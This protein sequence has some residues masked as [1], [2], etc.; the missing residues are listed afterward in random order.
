M[1]SSASSERGHPMHKMMVSMMLIGAAAFGPPAAPGDVVQSFVM[2]T[3]AETTSPLYGSPGA[4]VHNPFGDDPSTAFGPPYS[5]DLNGDGVEDFL[6]RGGGDSVQM[7]CAAGNAAW[8]ERPDPNVIGDLERLFP[9]EA[10]DMVGERVTGKT[11]DRGGWFSRD[12]YVSSYA[13]SLLL[14]PAPQIL[15]SGNY[16]FG[17]TA[18]AGLRFQIGTNT[19]YGRVLI[20]EVNPGM[21]PEEVDPPPGVGMLGA[22][23]VVSFAYETEPDK[24]IPIP[25]PEPGSAVLLVVGAGLL[26]LHRRARR[27]PANRRF[28]Q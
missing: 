15:A 10:G 5:M 16:Q 12:V 2:N 21:G 3:F 26:L 22:V 8:C 11:A 23:F 4:Y 13:V 17:T 25:I 1:A 6:I 14:P 9:L 28:N 7:E 18:Y 27:H 24:P 20:D 19:H